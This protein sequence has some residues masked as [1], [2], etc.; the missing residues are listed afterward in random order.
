MASRSPR[1]KHARVVENQKIT[2]LP[3]DAGRLCLTD[4]T[5]KDLLDSEGS[6]SRRRH[7][8]LIVPKAESML[9]VRPD[10]T[11]EGPSG[12]DSPYVVGE[13]ILVGAC[14]IEGKRVKQQSGAVARTRIHTMKQEKA[15]RV[16][17]VGG[18]GMKGE[19]PHAVAAGQ[20]VGSRRVSY[21]RT[22]EANWLSVPMVRCGCSER[23]C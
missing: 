23:R 16:S 12:V 5:I 4:A 17:P 20:G 19:S 21:L 10:S 22:Y 7:A 6:A 18:I 15:R 2:G 1:V 14:Q 8:R 9:G 11:E 3:V 13:V